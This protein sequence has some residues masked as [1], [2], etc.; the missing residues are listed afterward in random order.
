MLRISFVSVLVALAAAC[1]S[2]GGVPAMQTPET[3]QGEPVVAH[4]VIGGVT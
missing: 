3:F 4:L 1:A 2:P